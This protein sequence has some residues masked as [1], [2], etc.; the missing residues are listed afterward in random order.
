MSL[1]KDRDY[2]IFV[3]PFFLYFVPKYLEYTTFMN[4]DQF[5]KIVGF[6]KTTSYILSLLLYF[7]KNFTYKCAS[8]KALLFLSV[9]FL[10]VTYMAVIN[11]RKGLFVAVLLSVLY[12]HKFAKVFFRTVYYLSL[13]LYVFTIIAALTGFIPN[14]LAIIVKY[15]L[16]FKRLSL[17]FNYPGQLT[18]MLIPIVFLYYYIKGKQISVISNVF[19]LIVTIIIFAVSQTIMGTIVCIVYIVLFNIL[20]RKKTIRKISKKFIYTPWICA[21]ITVVLLFLYKINNGFVVFVDKVAN[22]RINLGVEMIRVYGIKIL[23][24]QFENNT[25]DYY[26]YLDSE[27]MHMFVAEGILF[28]LVALVIC[29]LIVNYVIDNSDIFALL[30]WTLVFINA[31]FNNG[32]FNLVMNPFVIVLTESIRY[33]CSRKYH[34]YIYNKDIELT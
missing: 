27:Y 7:F 26:Q 32:I 5:S 12:E 34:R 2:F 11:D 23:G 9:V 24:T 21:S 31:I 8:R 18:M 30:V 22:G 20:K 1:T 15:G 6:V 19:W 29:S 10:F 3:I 25:V 14:E 16:T 13:V 33:F 17:G 28:T 4:Y